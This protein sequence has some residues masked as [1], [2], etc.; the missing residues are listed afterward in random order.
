M[1]SSPGM[2]P[3][4]RR[5]R[6]LRFGG[7][8][9]GRRG[10]GTATVPRICPAACFPDAHQMCPAG[11][12]NPRRYPV[13]VSS[14]GDASCLGQ[15]HRTNTLCFRVKGEALMWCGSGLRLGWLRVGAAVLLSRCGALPALWWPRR[16]RPAGAAA[17]P[18]CAR[19]W[20]RPLA[21]TG[22]QRR[23]KGAASQPG[24]SGRQMPCSGESALAVTAAERLGGQA[25]PW[26]ASRWRYPAAR[27]RTRT[28]SLVVALPA[29]LPGGAFRIKAVILHAAATARAEAATGI[30]RAPFPLLPRRPNDG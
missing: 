15:P 27:G 28:V 11:F 1:N 4:T 9:P 5:D 29:A 22:W 14:R 21:R 20:T 26:V 7:N 2:D 16:G 25:N 10:P 19:S 8:L 18:G 12:C 17:R 13:S 3:R 30:P 6:Q 23:G 24:A